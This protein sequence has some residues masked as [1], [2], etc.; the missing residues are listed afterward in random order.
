MSGGDCSALTECTGGTPLPEVAEGT[1]CADEL[2][3]ADVIPVGRTSVLMEGRDRFAVCCR[4]PWLR[5]D[6][7]DD[8]RSLK[9]GF[10]AVRAGGLSSDAES[11]LADFAIWVTGTAEK[12]CLDI[13]VVWLSGRMVSETEPMRGAKAGETP[14]SLVT[15]SGAICRDF[16]DAMAGS[17]GARG[18]WLI[19]VGPCGIGNGDTGVARSSVKADRNNGLYVHSPPDRTRCR[20]SFCD[21]ALSLRPADVDDP[22]PELSDGTPAILPMLSVGTLSAIRVYR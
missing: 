12:D 22:T 3:G 21:E 13:S 6:R 10:C 9:C 16:D 1:D 18:A 15:G 17:V 8:G 5:D 19:K 11:F 4:S 14:N 7:L 2:V 20:I